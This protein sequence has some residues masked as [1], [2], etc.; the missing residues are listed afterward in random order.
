M[1]SGGAGAKFRPG[2]GD[3]SNLPERPA[4]NLRSVPGCAQIGPVPFPARQYAVPFLY[5]LRGRF[6]SCPSGCASR[7][8]VSSCPGHRHELAHVGS[9]DFG[10]N[11]ALQAASTILWFHPLAWR[12]GSAHR[13]ACDAVCDAISASYLGDVQAYCRT[14]ARV[15]LEGAGSFPAAALAM[16]RTCDV[17]RRIA[18]LQQRVFAAA[19]GRRTVAGVGLAGL[20]SLALLAESGLRWRSRPNPRPTALSRC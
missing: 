3:R 20:L 5:G 13:A 17:R 19:L 2:K 6:W 7:P 10:W 14:L 9:W 4:T 15:A 11:A 1:P 18:M 12:I 8:I 16:A